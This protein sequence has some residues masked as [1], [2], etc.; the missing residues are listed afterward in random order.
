MNAGIGLVDLV[1]EQDA[2]DFLIFQLAQND[3]QLRNFLLVHFADHDGDIDHRQH[4]AHIV[5]EF[6]R[7]RAIDEGVGV[8]HERRGG[9]G[10]LDAHLVMA[11]FLA[12][13]ADR[14]TGLDRA[15]ARDRA[16]A[17]QNRLEQGG[18][19]ALKRT[20]QRNGAG[21]RRAAAIIAVRG[22]PHLPPLDPSFDAG[23]LAMVSGVGRSG[24]G[25]GHCVPGSHRY[26]VP[27]PAPKL[28]P[29]CPWTD[30]GCSAID[31]FEPPIS[32]LAP[33]PIAIDASAV[34]PT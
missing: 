5:D 18:F 26:R 19:A 6:D 28:K 17:R 15:L 2:R 22:H 8:A 24:Q 14:V 34:A 32:A 31:R 29:V 33:R 12:G 27:M 11:R 7:A 23:R 4:R 9:G 3:L 25:A 21:T 16:G 30:N 1:E 10:Q 13:V 20:D